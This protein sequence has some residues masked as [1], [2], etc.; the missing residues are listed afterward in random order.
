[1]SFGSFG[2]LC[3]GNGEVALVATVDLQLIS[4]YIFIFVGGC[5]RML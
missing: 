1:M 5:A 4:L 2:S 3:G